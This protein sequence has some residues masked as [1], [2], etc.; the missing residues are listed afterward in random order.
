MSQDPTP[1]TPSQRL[2]HDSPRRLLYLILSGLLLF[3]VVLRV[4]LTFNREL[5]MDEFQHLHTTWML[6]RHFLIYKDFWEPHTPLLYYLM[7]PLFHFFKEGPGLVLAARV[8]L[9]LSAF[10]ILFVTYA[11]ARLAHDRLTSLLAVVVLSFMVIFVQK[12]IEVRPDQPFVLMWLA[13]LWVS[14][15]ALSG[16]RKP[17][18]FFWGGLI[19]GVGFLFSP[20]ALL[21]L[22]AMGFALFVLVFLPGSR[23]SF[24]SFVKIGCAYV[25]G[26]LIP[27]AACFAYFYELGT[28]REMFEYTLLEN[29]TFPHNV[30]PTY[31]LYLR[32]VCFFVLAF[33]GIFVRARRLRSAAR[34]ERIIHLALLLPTL[35]LLVVVLFFVA[36][37]FPQIALLFAPVLAIYGAEAFRD[38]LDRVLTPRQSPEAKRRERL[39]RGVTNCLY[40]AGAV[41]AAL[42]IPC[43]MLLLKDRPFAKTNAAQF[44][45]M[46]FVLNLTRPD[47]AVF[48]GEELYVFR[49][50][51]YFY[52]SLVEGVVWRIRHGQI[53]GD[54]T[55]SL[56]N[57]RCKVVIYDERV[58]SLPAP[59]QLFIK[60]TYEP[61]AE[62]GVF[63]SKRAF[64]SGTESVIEAES[65]KQTSAEDARR[66]NSE[67]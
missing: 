56:T 45:R 3:S 66:T 43:V 32:N 63:L 4:A 27:V 50:Q 46:E 40:L 1:E 54:I 51:A 11:L 48:D 57:A 36:Y 65:S 20:K 41:T 7:L 24:V 47:D 2:T 39:R 15:R 59:V 58:A 19:L 22:G 30:H 9:S 16:G 8:L 60:A 6:S 67:R 10:G 23:R 26:F 12:S 21:P 28:L 17:S 62:P 44:H 53:G 25:F 29:F 38:S 61:S 18:R 14:V 35:F 55:Q 34:D 5:D 52:G 64:D 31:L 37:P 49:P 13:S 42:G 33:A